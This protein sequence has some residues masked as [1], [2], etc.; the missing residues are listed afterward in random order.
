M[1]FFTLIKSRESVRKYNPTKKV[2]KQKLLRILDAGRLAPSAANYQ[3]WK[4]IVVSEQPLLDEIRA[5]YGRDWLKQAPHMLIVVGDHTKAWTRAYDGYNSIE[6]D[7][8]IAMDHLIL[9]A[10][11]EGIGTCWIEAY[12][13]EKL[14]KALNLSENEKVF[15]ITPLGYPVDGYEKG[16]K[17]RKPL[18]EIVD[19]R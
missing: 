13:P 8:T 16:E 17:K 14:R 5:C 15:S 10:E 3:P 2:E 19:W 4:F 12:D 6:T 1:E 18:D 11:N 9:A 7:L